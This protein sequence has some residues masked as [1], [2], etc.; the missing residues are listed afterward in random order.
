MGIK[1]YYTTCLLA[2]E[3]CESKE[4][5]DVLIANHED[6]PVVLISLDIE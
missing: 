4:A 5:P 3:G 2:F 6:D 1:K